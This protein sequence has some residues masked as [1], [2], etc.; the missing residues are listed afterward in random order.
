M[1]V[2]EMADKLQSDRIPETGSHQLKLDR[3][4]YYIWS[5][6]EI[7]LQAGVTS[8]EDLPTPSK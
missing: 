6:L 2:E 3:P 4:Q 7:Y 8:A 5:Q 1:T